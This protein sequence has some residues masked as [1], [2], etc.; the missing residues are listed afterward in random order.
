MNIN[1]FRKTFYFF[2]FFVVLIIFLNSILD[3]YQK[4]SVVL[5]KLE[6]F[7]TSDIKK[8][9]VQKRNRQVPPKNYQDL[10]LLGNEF[11]VG[12]WSAPFDWNV[13]G[14]HSILLQDETV[15]TFGSYGIESKKKNKDIRDDKDLILTNKF[16][17]KRD[18]GEIQWDVK[19]G[20]IDGAVYSGVDFDI[21]DPKKGVGD[22]SH[23]LIK[24]PIVLDAFC[25][26]VRV[27][28]LNNVFILGGHKEPKD[29]GIDS[30]NSTTFYNIKN[31]KFISG[32][33]L[34][35]SRWYGSIARLADDRFVMVGGIDISKSPPKPS[36]IPEIL[37]KNKDGIYKW[38]LLPQAES[39]DLFG[40][41][42]KEFSYPKT[43]LASDGNIFGI[44][45]NKLWMMDS[46]E[47]FKIKKVGEI[48]LVLGGLKKNFLNNSKEN[49]NTK[50][51]TVSSSVG[52][53]ASSLMIS[54]DKIIILG[55]KQKG[56]EYSSSN[57]V[58]LIDISNTQKPI[59]KKL[60]SMNYARAYANAV[61]LPTG[62]VFV[63][64][65][66]SYENQGDDGGYKYKAGS[67][68]YRVLT[69]E[70]Y[71]VE[72]DSWTELV[73]AEFPRDYHASSLLLPNGTILTN[74][75]DVWNAEIYYPP[76]LFEKDWNGKSVF[77]K[78]PVIEKID[79]S[80][81]RSS[82]VIMK[83]DDADKIFKISLISTGSVT[84]GEHS[85][86]KYLNINFRK[87]N[88]NEIIFNFPDNKNILQNGTYLIFALNSLNVPS[89][90]KI[91]Y[92]N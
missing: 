19:K 16:Q 91:I 92:L 76:Y 9:S 3:L 14:I 29:R 72:K 85:E 21:W 42:S 41:N 48:P 26:V 90:G 1:F 20:Y 68:G 49:N 15:M 44:S 38:R 45:Y 56:D 84:H 25:S 55:G 12:A 63:N 59:I 69:P 58:N 54:K 43:Y 71:N 51:L 88:K 79:K 65:G 6:S 74:G 46:K 7:V 2:I 17:L 87:N 83:V 32:N 5:S 23:T 22:E 27:F 33:N 30:Q 73:P 36:I 75:G 81:N 61:I 34:N 8:S 10:K 13:I 57:Q 28:D 70:I 40:N 52:D 37:E 62:D 80:I 31:K 66:Y 35:Y 82:E 86:L 89:E 64:G 78:R 39:N 24:K 50:L 11:Q 77:A 60:A 67:S 53:L 18:Q 4:R 47:D